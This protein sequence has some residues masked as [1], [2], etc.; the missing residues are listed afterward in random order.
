MEAVEGRKK[1]IKLGGR[2]GKKM[3]KTEEEGKRG[4]TVTAKVGIIEMG[5]KMETG[6][7]VGGM[8]KY[9]KA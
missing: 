5:F 7:G 8:I 4:G 1:G 3:V 9:S 6:A 2:K